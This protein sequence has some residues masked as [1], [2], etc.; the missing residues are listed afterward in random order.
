MGGLRKNDTPPKE[1]TLLISLKNAQANSTSQMLSQVFGS[2]RARFVPDPRTNRIV[3]VAP[4][5]KLSEIRK[6]IE[7]LDVPIKSPYQMKK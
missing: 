5:D 1:I 2:T 4:E 7:E 6:L 3:L